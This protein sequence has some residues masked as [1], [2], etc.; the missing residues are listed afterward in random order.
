LTYLTFLV[1]GLVANQYYPLPFSSSGTIVVLILGLVTITSGLSVGA[2]ALRAMTRAGVSPLPWRTP[3][4][5]VVDGPFRFSRNPLYVS[6][7]LMYIGIS[8]AVNTFWPLPLLVFA[9]AIVDRRTI[10]RE[11]RLLEKTFGEE[12]RRYKA[13][14]RRWI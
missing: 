11:E 3:G 8:V 1:L 7:T 14:V 10:L 13:R 4:K 6:L 9:V 2:I 5:L 12:Y